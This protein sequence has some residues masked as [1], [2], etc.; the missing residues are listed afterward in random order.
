MSIE[1]APFDAADYLTDDETIEAYLTVAMEDPDP[2]IFPCR[3]EFF[4][5]HWPA[6]VNVKRSAAPHGA[7]SPRR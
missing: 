3:N 7:P 1:T 4:R 5:C 6:S 2:E